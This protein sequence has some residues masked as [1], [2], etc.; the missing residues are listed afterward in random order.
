MD[1]LILSGPEV[2]PTFLVDLFMNLQK[3]Y[4]TEILGMV[5]ESLMVIL[6]CELCNRGEVVT[7]MWLL[8]SMF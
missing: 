2:L 5:F 6:Q 1:L 7:G 8:P 3:K 4:V